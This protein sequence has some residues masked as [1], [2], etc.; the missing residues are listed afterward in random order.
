MSHRRLIESVV[1]NSLHPQTCLW[2]PTPT[3]G[4]CSWELLICWIYIGGRKEER[5]LFVKRSEMVTVM[6]HLSKCGFATTFV[7]STLWDFFSD[8]DRFHT[9]LIYSLPSMPELAVFLCLALS[10]LVSNQRDR[11]SHAPPQSPARAASQGELGSMARGCFQFQRC[12]G[13]CKAG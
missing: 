2:Q 5:G 13:L 11:F 3:S 4:N 6:W 1:L 12:S 9:S 8:W 10:S 7:R